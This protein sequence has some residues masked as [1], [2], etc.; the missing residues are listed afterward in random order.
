LNSDPAV[1][2]YLVVA[3]ARLGKREEA[4]KLVEQMHE[5]AKQRYVP[6]Y[7]FGVAYTGLGDKDQAFQWLERSLQDRAWEITY[8]KV[9]AS[10]DGLRSDPRF[11]DLV[12]R[13]G[14]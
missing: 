5:Q 9:D 2:S 1:L 6:A 4:V 14:F 12:K 11:D 10:M 7:S 8:L 13:L 3:Y